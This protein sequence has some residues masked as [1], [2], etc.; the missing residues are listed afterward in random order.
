MLQVKINLNLNENSLA[1]QIVVENNSVKAIFQENLGQLSKA[2]EDQGFDSA[3]L[4]ISLSDK[5]GSED[6][7]KQKKNKQYFSDRLKRIDESGQVVRYGAPTA[8]INLTA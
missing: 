5:E 1:G 7:S 3:K 8:G 6:N 2:L 4:D